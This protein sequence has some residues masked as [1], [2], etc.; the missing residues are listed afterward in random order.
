MERAVAE[1][2]RLKDTVRETVAPVARHRPVKLL[3][4]TF[5]KAWADRVW[6][7]SAEAAFWQLLSLPP[8]LLALLGSLGYLGDLFGP[9]TVESVHEQLLSASRRVLA[10]SVVDNVVSPTIKDVLEHGR[11]DVISI[12]FLISLWAGSSAMATFV[13][14]ITIAYDMRDMRGAVRSRL[15]ALWLYIVSILISIFLLPMLVLGPAKIVSLFPKDD[16]GDVSSL[17]HNIYWP[18]ICVILLLA[19]T[20]LY[21]LSVP[22][23]LRWRRGLPGAVFAGGVFLL[24]SYLL[25]VYIDF[26]SYRAYSY[27]TLASPI[28]A[29]LFLFVLA[30]AILLGAEFNAAFEKLWPSEP[31]PS[32]RE[33]RQRRR[34]DRRARAAARRARAAARRAAA[35]PDPPAVGPGPV[36]GP[37]R[38]GGPPA[39]PSHPG[40]PGPAPQAWPADPSQPWS[41]RPSDPP[42][43]VGAPPASATRTADPADPRPRPWS[44]P[45]EPPPVSSR[46]DGRAEAWPQP[47]DGGRD[48]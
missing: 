21:H 37:G 43:W 38:V 22:Q 1:Q 46:G 18:A 44:A 45:P 14:T 3:R 12:G 26:V 24:G 31:A 15:I 32:R 34:E 28:A 19:L 23:R 16:R 47:R 25:R 2:Q 9:D 41:A 7:L 27:G 30:L 4:R 40:P 33:R 48:S 20:S 39:D 8:L 35:R 29:L 6:G 17:I 10:P 36:V 11:A 42:P 13:N 5:S